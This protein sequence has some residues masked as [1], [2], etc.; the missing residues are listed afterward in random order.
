VEID[1]DAFEGERGDLISTSADMCN[2]V[3][4]VDGPVLIVTI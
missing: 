2:Y 1:R 4:L 3:V